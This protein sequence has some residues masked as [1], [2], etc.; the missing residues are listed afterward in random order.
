MNQ[1]DIK[2]MVDR[3]NTVREGMEAGIDDWPI[4]SQIWKYKTTADMLESLSK[5]SS[6][7]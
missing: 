1:E 7:S 3:L 2:Q 6:I 4:A 5:Q